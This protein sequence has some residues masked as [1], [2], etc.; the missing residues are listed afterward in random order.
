IYEAD[1]LRRL[2]LPVPPEFFGPAQGRGPGPRVVSWRDLAVSPAGDRLYLA[3]RTDQFAAWALTAAGPQRLTWEVPDTVTSLTLSPDG[4][5]LALGGRN[6]EVILID[7]ARGTIRGRLQPPAAEE[8]D[9]VGT[10]AF[11]PNGT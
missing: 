1:A 3:N 8:V 7:T 5:T 2:A 10:L 11:A 9:R 6:G 4:A